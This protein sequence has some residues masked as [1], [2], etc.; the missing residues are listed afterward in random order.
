MTLATRRDN[1]YFLER[2]KSEHPVHYADLVAGRYKNASQAFI[3]AGLRKARSTLDRLHAA[4]NV[5][6][7]AERDSFLISI[8]VLAPLASPSSS[9]AMPGAAAGVI[10]RNK[11][12]LPSALA[13]Q[14]TGIIARRKLKMGIVMKELGRSQLDASLG[15]ALARGTL[16]QT[17]LLADLEAW[18]K[19]NS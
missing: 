18:V 6:S 13:G 14:I 16:I 15:M 4:W 9:P 5:A 11:T 7:P 19:T 8:G 1:G 10:A 12:H 3:A 17:D 2:L